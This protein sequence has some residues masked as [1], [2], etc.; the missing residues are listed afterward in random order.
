M[1][2]KDLLHGA[3]LHTYSTTEFLVTISSYE[4][5]PAVEDKVSEKK[6]GFKTFGFSL[7]VVRHPKTKEYLIVKEGCKQGWWLPGGRVDR[8]EGFQQT[9]VRETE[10]EAGLA[11]K[12]MGILRIEF[13][14]HKD[15]ARYLPS[16]YL[17][18]P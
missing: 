9:A 7:V 18:F 1:S 17:T 8:G 5:G 6:S 10:E 14:A 3:T 12:L 2:P 13:T 4:H 16:T 15:Y 11:V